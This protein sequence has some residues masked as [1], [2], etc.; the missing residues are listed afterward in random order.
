[1]TTTTSRRRTT[2][3]RRPRLYHEIKKRARAQSVLFQQINHYGRFNAP[4][5]RPPSPILP[6]PL[7]SPPPRISMIEQTR[8]RSS[9]STESPPACFRGEEILGD[10]LRA[11]PP[12]V[13]RERERGGE[14]RLRCKR[15]GRPMGLRVP[16]LRRFARKNLSANVGRGY[17]GEPSL[18]RSS[19]SPYPVALPPSLSFSR[20][21]SAFSHRL[22][23]TTSRSFSLQSTVCL[24]L[25]LC[26]TVS[27]L[28]DDEMT[29]LFRCSWLS[30][31]LLLLPFAH[32][33]THIVQSL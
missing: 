18:S 12:S 15:N 20:F 31:L 30:Q 26:V 2:T 24:L 19:A 29:V 11:F 5:P 22:R 6:P 4:F 1:M 23:F 16:L 14:V 21:N 28:C 25:T 32:L 7:S 3:T 17:V 10:V 9:V 8:R 27:R 13:K 33:L